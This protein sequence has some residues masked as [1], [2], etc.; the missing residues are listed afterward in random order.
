MWTIQH[1]TKG[2]IN[3]QTKHTHGITPIL[4]RSLV[5]NFRMIGLTIIKT[6]LLLPAHRITM[7]VKKNSIR[8]CKN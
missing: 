6:T 7:I 5:K 8:L 3:R 1:I 2:T 4:Y